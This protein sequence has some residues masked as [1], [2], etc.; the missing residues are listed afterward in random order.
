ILPLA[1]FPTRR[2]SDLAG[3]VGRASGVAVQGLVQGEALCWEPG[4][5]I[6]APPARDGGV[7]AE[8]WIDGLDRCV[9]SER[10]DCASFEKG[11]P[12]VRPRCPL[13]APVAVGEVAIARAM[14]RLH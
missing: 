6:S 7:D 1:S 14:D 2:S 8:Q 4:L 12:G 3:G 5:T 10:E 13:R 9:R 11:S